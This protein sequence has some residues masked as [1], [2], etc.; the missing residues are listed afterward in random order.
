MHRISTS[1]FQLCSV[2]S[3]GAKVKDT[4]FGGPNPNQHK[5][6]VGACTIITLNIKQ[7]ERLKAK[8]FKATMFYVLLHELKHSADVDAGILPLGL[9][10]SEK[11]AIDTTNVERKNQGYTDMREFTDHTHISDEDIKRWMKE[12]KC[13]KNDLPNN[14]IASKTKE[15]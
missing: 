9:A 11:R 4:T 5:K 14:S 6:G 2:S 13:E 8:K 10:E 7:L 12:C 15:E 1:K 3:T